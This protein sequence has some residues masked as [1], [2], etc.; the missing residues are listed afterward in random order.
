VDSRDSSTDQEAGGIVV[1]VDEAQASG[2]VWREDVRHRPTVEQDR[3]TLAR[4][5]E[6]DA[7]PFEVQLYEWASDPQALRIDRAQRSRAGQHARH[8]R[9]LKDR[10]KR[11]QVVGAV[12]APAWSRQPGGC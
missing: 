8:V 5:I 6:F 4:L 10:A 11:P 9:R 3:D 1:A 2:H 12:D 7:D